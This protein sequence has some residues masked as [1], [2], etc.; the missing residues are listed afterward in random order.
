[1]YELLYD[2]DTSF[3]TSNASY[4][5]T[6]ISNQ[7]IRDELRKLHVAHKNLV[8]VEKVTVCSRRTIYTRRCD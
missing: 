5:E 7:L 8:L 4:V 2:D 6:C 1:M 3:T